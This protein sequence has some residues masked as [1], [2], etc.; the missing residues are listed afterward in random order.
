MPFP[1]RRKT[2]RT[3]VQKCRFWTG[4]TIQAVAICYTL[5]ILGAC[6]LKVISH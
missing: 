2:K 4:R 6:A 1:E 3:K 5:G